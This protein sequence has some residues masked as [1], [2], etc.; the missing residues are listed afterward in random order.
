MRI[1]GIITMLSVGSFVVSAALAGTIFF[2]DRENDRAMSLTH[3]GIEALVLSADADMAH[4]AIRGVVYRA[5]H[6]A[7]HRDDAV[8]T[9]I[10]EE[11]KT[12]TK[13]LE[14]NAGALR[15][16]PIGPRIEPETRRIAPRIDE[17][18]VAARSIVDAVLKGG[19]STA[20]ASLDR[21]NATFKTLETEM[22][23]LSG[24]I[25]RIN[26][27]F[28]EEARIASVYGSIAKYVGLFAAILIALVLYQV[29]SRRVSSPI[30][31]LA[32]SMHALSEG[33]L[34][35]VIGHTDRQDE[36]G[37]MSRAVEIFRASMV[38]RQR[39]EAA[40]QSEQDR[41]DA[42]RREMERIIL[43]FRDDVSVMIAR[44]SHQTVTMSGTSSML[45][46]VAQSTAAQAST[47]AQASTESSASIQTIASA[48]EEMGASI[49]E[50]AHRA[51]RASEMVAGAASD[52]STTNRQMAALTETARQI[53]TVVELIRGIADQ[54]NLLALNATIEAA[55]AGDAGR[56]FAVVASEVKS[57]AEQTA[58]AT[59]DIGQQ[60]TAIQASARATEEAVSGMTAKMAEVNTLT[61]SIAASVAQQDAA[62]GEIAQNVNLASQGSADVSRSV[63][64]VMD[65]ITQTE[66]AAT[67]ARTVSDELA[68]LSGEFSS[69]VEAFL[70][71]INNEVRD[72]RGARRL[73]TERQVTVV[74]DGR[75]ERANL[76]EI[77]TTGAR[78][79]IRGR[80]A[81]GSMVRMTIDGDGDYAA[82]IMWVT[83][84]ECGIRFE[85]PIAE[86]VVMRIANKATA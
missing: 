39:L 53:G 57:L 20:E 69:T 10:S 49:R 27:E 59:G 72:R 64:G 35:M 84:E 58:R 9:E 23:A 79:T 13:T 14:D 3:E 86:P 61:A 26:G 22:A 71:S 76:T 5:L 12:Y 24:A 16:G 40:A 15:S 19:G 45:T 25:E 83:A 46:S 44:L 73:I 11:I 80:F 31:R 48:T 85:S 43:K 56:G 38:E 82:R 33:Q 66:A 6:T 68:K 54:T 51:G 70:N 78:L 29:A 63:T 47:V 28:R 77:S 81:A 18:I 7:S 52:A 2:L 37:D 55:R 74:V 36:V 32:H 4:D 62:T 50:I 21:F 42:E 8:L 41:R 17:Y 34:D 65:A 30:D 67:N 75:S 1:R 60:I